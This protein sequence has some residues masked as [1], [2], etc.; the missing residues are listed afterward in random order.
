MAGCASA[1][2]REEILEVAHGQRL[3][4]IV[5]LSQLHAHLPECFNLE[6]RE[7]HKLTPLPLNLSTDER[8]SWSLSPENNTI[9]LAADG[10]NGGLWTIDLGELAACE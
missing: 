3:R 2:G 10:V 1:F 8:A 9:A 4:K 5:A 6:S 7:L